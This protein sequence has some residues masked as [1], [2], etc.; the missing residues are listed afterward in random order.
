MEDVDTQDMTEYDDDDLL[1]GPVAMGEH[2]LV[3]IDS[4]LRDVFGNDSR[5]GSDAPE[6]LTI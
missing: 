4:Y 6:D 2:E 1:L 5:A 3:Y